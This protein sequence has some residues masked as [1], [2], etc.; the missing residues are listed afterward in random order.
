MQTQK[1][2]VRQK[3]LAAA[4][5]EFYNHNFSNA[6]LRNIAA[7][8]NITPG[9]IYR[10][11]KNKIELY[12]AVVDPAWQGINSLFNDNSIEYSH[13][14]SKSFL[15]LSKEIGEVFIN[16]QKQFFI[17]INTDENSPNGNVKNI[18]LNQINAQI[19]LDMKKDMPLKEIDPMFLNIIAVAIIEAMIYIFRHF[20]GNVE[21]LNT[22]LYKT[23]GLIL[24]N[25]H[26]TIAEENVPC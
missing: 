5:D 25:L 12:N 7:T 13:L 9:N 23:M 10:Y 8:A 16:N 15:D 24:H 3:I 26:E 2:E 6:S 1:D 4:T 22:M 14:T 11:F 17:L 18:I 19:T 21:K 20:D